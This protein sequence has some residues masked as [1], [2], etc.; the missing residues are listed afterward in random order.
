MSRAAGTLANQDGADVN[1]HTPAVPAPGPA[2]RAAPGAV[3]KTT[4]PGTLITVAPT[5]AE[6]RRPALPRS[7][8]PWTNWSTAK[9]CEA[10]ARPSST[11]TSATTTRGRPS[12]WAGS[13]HGHRPAREHRPHRAALHR[14]RGHRPVRLPARVLDA[15]PDACS[16][17]CGTVNFGDDVF[18]N[19][20]PFMAEL[21][22]LTQE[23]EIVPEFELFDLGQVA[24][25]RRL[26]G[27][28]RRAVRRARPLRPGHGGAGRHA[29]RRPL[30][31]RGGRRA[32]GGGDLVGHRDRPDVAAGDVRGPVGR[33]SSAGRHGR[34]ADIRP[35]AAG[36]RQCPARRACG[37]PGAARA[38]RADARRR[39][40]RCW[41]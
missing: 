24:S 3:A 23:R 30:A 33:G 8:S 35:T 12:T 4:G 39:P 21:Y 14:R 40:A 5:G 34:Y 19:P 7:R 20:W 27:H 6:A 28:L 29:G 9:E 16:L 41:V 26:L 18:M 36:D 15:E 38:A 1:N 13:R 25:L 11:S 32:P 37:R 31:R 22:R 2:A 17:T 10:P